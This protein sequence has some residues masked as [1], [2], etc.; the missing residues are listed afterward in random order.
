MNLEKKYYT[1]KQVSNRTKVSIPTLKF[2]VKQFRIQLPKNSA[3]RRIFSEE[4]IEK[5]LLIKHFRNQE[6]LTLSGIKRKLATSSEAQPKRKIQE[7]LL[8]I[9]KELLLIKNILEQP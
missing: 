7:T 1:F 6:K 9:Q 4:D 5:I 2:W 3:G 8:W